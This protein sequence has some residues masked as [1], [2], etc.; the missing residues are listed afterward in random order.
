MNASFFFLEKMGAKNM[1]EKKAKR[2]LQTLTCSFFKKISKNEQKFFFRN[3]FEKKLR[4]K[5]VC[6]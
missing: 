4:S 6:E 3:L 5:W 2:K 1:I